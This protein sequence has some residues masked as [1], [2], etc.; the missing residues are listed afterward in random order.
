MDVPVLLDA[1]CK[2]PHSVG[3]LHQAEQEAYF[4][5]RL[6]AV[7]A[8]FDGEQERL[9]LLTYLQQQGPA[10]IPASNYV[11]NVP[12]KPLSLDEAL[13]LARAR[14]QIEL[15]FK[16]WKRQGQID[17][18]CSRKPWTILCEVYARLMAM[19]FQPRLLLLDCWQFPE[20]SLIK[21]SQ[22]VRAVAP[23]LTSALSGSAT[24][25]A[26]LERLQ[27]SCRAV[28]RALTRARHIQYL[29]TVAGT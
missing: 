17:K 19:V 18:W 23:L 29:S 3:G 2:E 27:L 25:S 26:V 5:S 9:D 21:A 20:R 7:T 16:L 15:L 24:L 22:A 13:I 1:A 10:L 11:T 28:V 12:R 14:Q 6:E 8:V 4:L